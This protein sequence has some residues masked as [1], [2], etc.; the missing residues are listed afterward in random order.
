VQSLHVPDEKQK[1][2]KKDFD[3]CPFLTAFYAK[4]MNRQKYAVYL[5][6][7]SIGLTIA[8]LL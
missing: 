1:K 8:I 3:F 5:I 4:N 6:L 7:F 2:A